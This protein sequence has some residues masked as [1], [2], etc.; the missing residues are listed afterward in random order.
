MALADAKLTIGSEFSERTGVIIGSAIGGLAT[1]E[2]EFKNLLNAGPRK[3]SPFAVPATSCQSCLRS[4]FHQIR[5]Q[6]SHQLR[7]DRLRRG[8][9]GHR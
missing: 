2:E 6:R 5:G 3:I 9:I 4:R 7:C 8:N 1:L